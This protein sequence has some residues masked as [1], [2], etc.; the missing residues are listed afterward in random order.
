MTAKTPPKSPASK[1]KPAPPIL[2]VP[3]PK[4]SRAIKT[5]QIK[6]W[7][8]E[9]EGEKIILYS[10]SGMGK[11]TLSAMSPNPVFIG[12]DDGGRKIKHPLTGENLNYIPDV[13]TFDDVR[14]ALHQ[15]DLFDDYKTIVIDTA[16]KFELLA[17]DWILKNVK[18]EHGTFPKNIENYG[19]GKGHRHLY[20]TMRLPLADFDILIRRGKNICILCQ[21]QQIEV[22]H[23]GGEN[24][25][26]DAPKLA[27]KHGRQVPSIWG[28]WVE[29][30]DHVFKIDYETIQS[31]GGKA[32]ASNERCIRVHPE[33]YF[34][35]KS[36]T[37]SIAYPTIS[38]ANPQDDSIWKFLFGEK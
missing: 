38:F 13:N 11:T 17:L 24:Y 16:T 19:W 12:L 8:G 27:P 20:D 34:K 21:M 2:T 37:I 10:D 26:C 14:D 18:T 22:S 23:S 9:N 6:S 5:F 30:A 36:R 25:F 35:A 31:E 28:M 3:T 32:V 7:S 33:I 29:W 15:L 1:K 4:S